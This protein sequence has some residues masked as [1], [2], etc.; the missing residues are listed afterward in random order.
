MRLSRCERGSCSTHVKVREPAADLHAVRDHAWYAAV[1]A[2]H[3]LH[4]RLLYT[5]GCRGL[6]LQAEGAAVQV[7][8]AVHAL[9]GPWSTTQEPRALSHW[10]IAHNMGL[11]SL[12][13]SSQHGPCLTGTQLTTWASSH[14]HKAHNMGLVTLVLSSQHG[15]CHTGT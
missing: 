11:V 15:P 8:H 3:I 5:Q 12:A 7:S 14:W 9:M 13:H 1:H 6:H 2:D 4:M 10:H